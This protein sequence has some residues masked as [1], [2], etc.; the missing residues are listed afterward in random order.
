MLLTPQ[1][2]FV[3]I[4]ST[5]KKPISYVPI[6]FCK[7]V[8]K[9]G[10]VLDSQL[11][12]MIS[13]KSDKV[14]TNIFFEA[15][16]TAEQ[17]VR[18]LRPY[19][20]SDNFEHEFILK[21][22]IG[23]GNFSSVFLCT[24][25]ATGNSFAAKRFPKDRLLSDDLELESLRNEV[26]LLG[27]TDH[28][29]CIKLHAVYETKNYLFV[30]SNLFT[31]SDLLCRVLLEDRL[32]VE[33]AL[34]ICLQLLKILAHLESRQ[35]IHRDIKPLNLLFKDNT[36][37]S[38]ICL[39]DFG[40]ST[41]ISDSKKLFSQ[42]GTPGYVAP[43]VLSGDEYDCRADVYSAGVVLHFMVTGELPSV[44]FHKPG[45]IEKY[46]DSLFPPLISSSVGVEMRES[47]VGSEGFFNLLD[48]MLSS[49][50]KVRLSAE[51]A[52]KHPAFQTVEKISKKDQQEAEELSTK[53]E[54]TT[55]GKE[56]DAKQ[57]RDSIYL[58]LV[59]PTSSSNHGHKLSKIGSFE[60]GESDNNIVVSKPRGFSMC[61]QASRLMENL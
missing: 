26:R 25:K 42:C 9:F 2:I 43:E 55:S 48:N 34:R 40:F 38:E 12:H 31:G 18:V 39:V 20:V 35:I 46:H 1:R 5:N 22:K 13:L 17:W 32:Q 44:P 29:N 27:S 14:E 23:S 4:S 53:A 41:E 56:I 28:P 51:Q 37:E 60:D 24:E 8:T 61:N 21:E 57:R 54:T 58:T 52:T 15:Q 59:Q 45:F 19:T 50:S 47:K 16:D 6:E 11:V 3:T 33:T 30:L 49:D 7:I 36:I 10:M